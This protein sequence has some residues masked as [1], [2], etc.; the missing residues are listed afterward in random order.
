MDFGGVGMDRRVNDGLVIFGAAVVLA[1]VVAFSAMWRTEFKDDSLTD[2]LI[3]LVSFGGLIV[4]GAAFLYLKGTFEETRRAAEVAENQLKLAKISRD[5]SFRAA[6]QAA[7]P[8]LG[9]GAEKPPRCWQEGRNIA[10]DFKLKNFGGSPATNIMV[11]TWVLSFPQIDDYEHAIEHYAR[12]Y[13]ETDDY[14]L[15]RVVF[16]QNGTRFFVWTTDERKDTHYNYLFV[17][18]HYEQR[19]L[20]EV[21]A[22][23]TFFVID[24]S[25][26]RFKFLPGRVLY[27]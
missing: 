24:L 11:A 16:P 1:S 13:L 10:C 22:F 21:N 8:W 9:I 18:V 23:T 20:A 15:P 25:Y 4:S 7:R 2:W 12:S 26:G 6:I 17:K 14:N 27:S 19:Y 3:A 5:D